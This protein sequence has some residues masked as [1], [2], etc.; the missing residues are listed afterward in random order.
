MDQPDSLIRVGETVQVEL[1]SD[2]G[3]YDVTV[4]S[5]PCEETGNCWVFY[6]KPENKIFYLNEFVMIWRVPPKP[7][8]VK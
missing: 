8:L 7:Q 2:E 4:V 5:L 1:F 6:F 3:L